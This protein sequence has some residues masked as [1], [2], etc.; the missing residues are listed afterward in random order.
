MATSDNL[1]LQAALRYADFGYRVFP[2]RPGGSRPLT[3][4]GFHDA[5]TDAAQL[6]R[7]WARHPSANVALS[8]Q[9]LLVVDRDPLAD[10]TPNPWLGDDPDRLL[11]LAAGATTVTPRGGRHHA[12]RKPPGKPWRCTAGQLAPHVDTRTD[13]GYFVVPPSRRAEGCYQWV[14]GCALDVP[15]DRLPDPPPWLTEQLDRLAA[16][17][18]A[19]PTPRPGR[20]RRTSSPPASGT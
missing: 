6:E 9:G 18:P 2:C 5:T 20:R 8:A 7:W 10:G 12:F 14:P 16:G 1:C 3:E 11:D 19:G 4:H 15:P 17:S 13:G